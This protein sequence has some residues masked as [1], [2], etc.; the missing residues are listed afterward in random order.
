MLFGE[1]F[2]LCY[3]T[4]KER[5]KRITTFGNCF[6]WQK[7]AVL[8]VYPVKY[9]QLLTSYCKNSAG[10]RNNSM[11]FR[12]YSASFRKYSMSF[13]KYSMS[14]CRYSLSFRKYSL[15]FRKYSAGFCKYSLSFRKNSPGFCHISTGKPVGALRFYIKS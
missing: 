14:I 9:Q 2:R 4:R 6:R 8:T 1:N 5:E 13:R 11:S 15:S 7:H 12:K 10:F 3:L